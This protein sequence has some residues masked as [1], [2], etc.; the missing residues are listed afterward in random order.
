MITT[1]VIKNAVDSFATSLALDTIDSNGVGFPL[2]VFSWHPEMDGS[3][4]GKMQAPGRWP[5]RKVV[6][7]MPITVEGTIL[8]RTTTEY[9]S[10]R[11]ALMAKCFPSPTNT[12]YDPVKFELVVDG[13][14]NTYYAFC[15]LEDAAGALD[16]QSTRSPT[17]SKFMLSYSCRAGYWTGP[18]GLV[19]L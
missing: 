14:A 16:T 5:W 18:T 19:I 13:D 3:D 9:W 1:L 15:V 7:N 11:K 17:V 6:R 8:A 4:I 10:Q 12:L 2:D